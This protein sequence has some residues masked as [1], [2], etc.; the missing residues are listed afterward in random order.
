MNVF[1]KIYYWILSSNSC[2]EDNQATPDEDAKTSQYQNEQAAHCTDSTDRQDKL[3]IDDHEDV[4]H[5]N[6]ASRMWQEIHNTM[7]DLKK[8]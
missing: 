2:Q 3:I 6:E 4:E 1:K 5:H 7:K 8:K